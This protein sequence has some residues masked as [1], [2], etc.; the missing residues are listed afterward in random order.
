MDVGGIER[1]ITPRTKAIIPVHLYG[2]PADMDPILEIARRHG[3]AVIEDA[4]QAHGAEYKGKRAGSL[5]DLACFS[6]YPGK[7]MGAYGEGGMVTTGDPEMAR[8][9]RSLR[10]WGQEGRHNHVR[11]G[12]NYRMDEIQGAVLRVKLRHLEEWTEA[13]RRHAAHYDRLLCGSGVRTP[14]TAA[15]VRHVRHIYAVRSD[16][17]DALQRALAENGVQTGIHYPTPVHLQ[18]AYADLGYTAGDFPESESAASEVL[19]LPLY[20]ELAADDVAIVTALVREH[21]D[22]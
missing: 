8:V 19:S 7:N 10:D 13:R 18:P 1:A 15:E 21:A 2:Q 12:F 16:N 6:Y 4:A 20:P 5:G 11:R 17:R 3:L 9:I 14:A 22:G